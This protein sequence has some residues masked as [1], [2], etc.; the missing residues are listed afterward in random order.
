MATTTPVTRRKLYYDFS[1]GGGATRAIVPVTQFRAGLTCGDRYGAVLSRLEAL[2]GSS[3]V[4][5]KERNA[6][7]AWAALAGNSQAGNTITS[8]GAPV[9]V[10]FIGATSGNGT[11]AI[12]RL[13]YFTVGGTLFQKPGQE[14]IYGTAGSIRDIAIRVRRTGTGATTLRGVLYVQRQHSMEV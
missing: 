2:T 10:D 14:A 12:T 7:M 4:A 3:P 9:W 6:V 13:P 1:I 8:V 5:N 11:G